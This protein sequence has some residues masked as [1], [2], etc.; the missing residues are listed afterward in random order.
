MMLQNIETKDSNNM[1]HV[2]RK[3]LDSNQLPK[4]VTDYLISDEV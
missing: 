2:K 4:D 3:F 1:K